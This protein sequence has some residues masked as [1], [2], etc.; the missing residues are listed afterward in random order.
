MA[1]LEDV[2]DRYAEGMFDTDN[3]DPVFE[4]HFD[5]VVGGIPMTAD[6]RAAI[7]AFLHTLTDTAF[8]NNP[9]FMNPFE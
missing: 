3:Q 1:T 6:D 4:N 7:V 8:V 5:E 9:E 2:L